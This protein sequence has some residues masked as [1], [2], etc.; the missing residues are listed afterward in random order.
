MAISRIGTSNTFLDWIVKTQELTIRVPDF[1]DSFENLGGTVVANTNVNIA[2]D[3]NVSEN[4]TVRGNFILVDSVYDDLTVAGN[5][6][7]QG[8]ITTTNAEFSNLTI[9]GVVNLP[10]SVTFG[11]VGVTNFIT[12]NVSASILNVYDVIATNSIDLSAASIVV[13]DVVVTENIVNLNTASLDV[14]TNAEIYNALNVDSYLVSPNLTV[15]DISAANVFVTNFD[16]TSDE[17]I[18]NDLNSVG[19][20][21]SNGT[22]TGSTLTADSV[23]VNNAIQ[24]GNL[25]VANITNELKVGTDANIYGN[26]TVVGDYSF[27]DY[28]FPPGSD[29]NIET[30]NVTSLIGEANTQIY[31][32]IA[33]ST[34]AVTVASNTE[35]FIGFVVALG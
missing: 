3:V 8:T 12:D 23:N 15:T 33:N 1:I 30:A 31:N 32:T 28:D 6:E 35:A 27:G 29:L 7:A 16:V 11:N 22:F 17:I 4:V 13:S 21:T 26:L 10:S 18:S 20:V 14:G 2:H 9:D 5:I 25:S 19:N 24:T 34:A